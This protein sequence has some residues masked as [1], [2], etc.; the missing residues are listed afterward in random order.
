MSDAC[1]CAGDKPTADGAEE[2]EHEPE[3]LIDVG[4]LRAASV[5]GILLLAG[6]AT[7]WAAGPDRLG[8][9][10]LWAALLVGASTFVPSTL[11]RLAKRKIGVGTL[12]TIAAVGAVLLGTAVLTFGITALL[13][14]IFEHRQIGRAHV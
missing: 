5:A 12:M 11:R 3:R 13:V 1:G 9:A 6:Y 2:S 7:D 10:L 4:E 14:T 8:Q